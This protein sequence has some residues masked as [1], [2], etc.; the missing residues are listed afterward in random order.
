MSK[1]LDHNDTVLTADH[2]SISLANAEQTAIVQDVSITIGRG[3]CLAMVGESGSGKSTVLRAL[4]GLLP[5]GLVLHKGTILFNG[6]VIASPVEQVPLRARLGQ[7]GM[8]FQEP[9]TALNPLMPVGSQIGEAI[10]LARGRRS[11]RQL[12]SEVLEL[13][14]RVGIPDAARRAAQRSF[15]LSGGLRQRVVIAIA[16]AAR[17]KLLLCDEPTTALDVTVQQQILDLLDEL[18]REDGLALLYVSHDLAVVSNIA[19]R[20]AVMYAGSLVEMGDAR[21]VIT[22]AAHPYTRGLLAAAPRFSP[23]RL[24]LYPIPG[25]P[26]ST[27]A[28]PQG[29]RFHPRCVH[30]AEL[31]RLTEPGLREW[32]NRSVACVRLDKIE[33]AGRASVEGNGS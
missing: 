14:D 32:D 22:R 17:P 9:M 11:R 30:A 8:V 3:E 20:I 31:C 13:M 12:R 7:M 29:C 5:N 18:R 6:Q 24:K 21:Q 15:E 16:I 19:D 27:T 33:Q 28:T 1:K 2:L 26:P 23:E 4:L 25:L 10:S